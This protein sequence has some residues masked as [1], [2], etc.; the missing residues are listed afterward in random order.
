VQKRPKPK[1]YQSEIH[2]ELLYIIWFTHETY[3]SGDNYRPSSSEK[4]FMGKEYLVLKYEE[5]IG[6]DSWYFYFDPKPMRWKYTNSTMMRL[7]RWR[8]HRT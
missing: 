3:R 1:R 8:I 4:E 6:K 2:E 5:G 7:K